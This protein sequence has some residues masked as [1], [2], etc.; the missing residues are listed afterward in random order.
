MTITIPDTFCTFALGVMSVWLI[1]YVLE[2]F[3]WRFTR[4]EEQDKGDA[5]ENDEYPP[6]R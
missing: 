1:L 4:T 5:M 6:T 3:G 2:L